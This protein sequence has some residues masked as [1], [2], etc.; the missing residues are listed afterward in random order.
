[1][2]FNRAQR[3]WV[4]RAAKGVEHAVALRLDARLRAC[5]ARWFPASMPFPTL[6]SNAAETG[7][8]EIGA[9]LQ[10]TLPFG[11]I[12]FR[13]FSDELWLIFKPVLRFPRA[14]AWP[15]SG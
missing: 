8:I 3:A 13:Y 1:M 2:P 7:I 6:D 15:A 4:Y 14:R 11:N 5:S 10:A 9:L 12:V